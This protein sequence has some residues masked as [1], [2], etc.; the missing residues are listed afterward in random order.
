VK[1]PLD[2]E[3]LPDQAD[4]LGTLLALLG[5]LYEE[6]LR[7]VYAYGGLIGYQSLLHSPFCYV[8]H[9]V[10][11]P[12]ALTA[13]DLAGVTATLAPRPLRLEGMV[14]GLNR[15][16]TAAALAEALAPAQAAYRAAAVPERLR[17]SVE[18]EAPDRLARWML[19][20]LAGH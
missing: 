17:L 3:D 7:A 6:D 12:G 5:A 9:D 15:R 20:T 1:V 14:D 16:A 4:P 11:V 10:I 2:A 18:R 13:G 19:A 8:P